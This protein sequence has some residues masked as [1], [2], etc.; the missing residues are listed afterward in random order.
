MEL[1]LMV[2]VQHVK[3]QLQAGND[4]VLLDVRTAAEFESVHIDGSLNV[5]LDQIE[6]QRQ[7]LSE[8]LKHPV[9]LVCRSG[10]R[11]R[12][13]AAL[14]QHVNLPNL[15]ILEGGIQAWQAANEP[16]KQGRQRWALDR[17]VRGLA[18][19]IVLF[20]MI[21]SLFWSPLRWVAAF[22]GAGLAY[23]ALTDSCAMGML[24]SKLPYNRQT[25]CQPSFTP[26]QNEV[27]A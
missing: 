1:P 23:S 8:S 6:Q 17:Q 15:H 19:S 16:V 3:Q 4:L 2:N 20:S 22:M 9:V 25:S 14:L 13:A 18:G 5:A 24:L 12:Q 7:Q 10:N 26:M 11:A 21:G 27:K